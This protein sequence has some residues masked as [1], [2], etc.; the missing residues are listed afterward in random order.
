MIEEKRGMDFA[1]IALFV[2]NRPDHARRTLDALLNNPEAKDSDLF[3]FSDGPKNDEAVP[4]VERVRWELRRIS[5]FR[6][7]SIT[8]RECNLGLAASII[9]GVTRLCRDFGR[10]IVLEDDLLVAPRFLEFMNLVLERY[11]DEPRVMQV[12][13]YMYPVHVSRAPLMG[14]L[15]SISCWG[16]ATW[17]RAW[18]AYDPSMSFYARLKDDGALRHRFDM[19]GVYGYFDMLEQQRAGRL[20]SWGVIWNLSVFAKDGL[21][22]CPRQSLVSNVGFDGTGT[23]TVGSGGAD[24]G[25]VRLWDF[26]GTFELPDRI[27]VDPA[28]YEASREVILAAQKGWRTWARKLLPR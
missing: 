16:W 25:A 14:F 12:S 18:A 28:Y 8:E 7:V 9:T 1:P 5:G 11:C 15:P 21:V 13:G 10:V 4:M 19:D 26:D 2:Y 20:D 22:L 27:E 23:H 24:L 3:V 17:A 6:S